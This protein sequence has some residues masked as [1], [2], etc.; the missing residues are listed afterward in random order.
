MPEIVVAW[1]DYMSYRLTCRGY[2][3]AKVE[4]ILR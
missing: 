2:D 4:Q 3:L 1:T